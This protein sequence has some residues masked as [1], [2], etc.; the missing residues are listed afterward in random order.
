MS[1]QALVLGG[2][3]LLGEQIARRLVETGWDVTVATR[4]NVPLAES[5]RAAVRLETLDRHVQGALEATVGDRFDSVVDVIPYGASDA[6]QLLRLAGRVDSIVAISSASVY[7]DQAGRPLLDAPE[8]ERPVPIPESQPTVHP[9][10]QSYAGRKAAVEAVLLQ[11]DLL[12]ATVVRPGAIY[13][14]NDLASREWYFVKRALDRRD[15]V[16]LADEGKSR[17]HQVAAANVA[18]LVRLALGKPGTRALNA[19]DEVAHTV[20]EIGRAVIEI[21]DWRWKEVLFAG[22]PTPDGVGETPWTTLEPFVLDMDAAR[23]ELGYRDVLGHEEALRRVCDWLERT[24]DRER[25]QVTLP[26][27]AEYYG[28]LFGY[29][30]E[31]RF[32]YRASSRD[33]RSSDE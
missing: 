31:D 22:P 12:P 30:A 26:R 16:V 2:S 1:R 13:G 24:V 33:R 7:A 10:A 4:G 20:A 8:S 14:E 28:G 17:F 18:E 11:Q 23:A 3:G 5:L 9:D 6:Q 29:D 15:K 19:G 21:M 27:A 32:E 25:W